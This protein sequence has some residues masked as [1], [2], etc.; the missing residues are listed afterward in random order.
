MNERYWL[1][2]PFTL[3]PLLCAVLLAIFA[4]GCGHAVSPHLPPPTTVGEGAKW[5]QVRF[6]L[7]WPADREP[8]VPVV[9]LLA[10]RIVGPAIATHG[11]SIYLWRLHQRAVR[12]GGGHQLTFFAFMP[13][14]AFA[15]MET[16]VKDSLLLRELLSNGIVTSVNARIADGEHTDELGGISDQKWPSQI[17]SAWPFFANGASATWLAMVDTFATQRCPEA[18]SYTELLPCFE[19]VS[20][21][22]DVLWRMH[23]Q[24]AFLHHLNAIFSYRPLYIKKDVVF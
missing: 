7:D 17:Q 24:H 20:A 2:G 1:T 10:Q 14:L 8:A 22:L 21:D 6:F 5:H 13:P 16:G 18:M 23:G 9:L 12:D 4:I 3:R 19:R 11:S 15:S